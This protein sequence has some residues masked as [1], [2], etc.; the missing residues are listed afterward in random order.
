MPLLRKSVHTIAKSGSTGLTGDV[1]LS[2]GTNVTLTQ[3]GQDISIAAAAAAGATTALDNLASV[4][5]N[6]ALVLATNDGF[7]LGST[8]KQWSDVFL[9]EG[10]VINWDNGDA[11]LT[12]VADVVTL[13]GADLKIS[14]PGT[15]SG[16]VATIDGTQT[17][18]NKS[19]SEAQLTFTDIT[20]G[21]V[22]STKHGFAQKS[23]ADATKFLN[24]GATPAWTV[25]ANTGYALA[26]QTLAYSGTPVD[27][28]IYFWCTGQALLS[29][30]AS[31]TDSRLFV[32]KAGT[33]KAVYGTFDVNGTLG[34][35]ES[36]TYAI[37][38]NN[39][40]DTTISSTAV[41]S[42]AT[43]AFS[44][45]G[46]SIAVVAGDYVELK[47]TCP[48]WVTNPTSVAGSVSIYIE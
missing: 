30:T 19:M 14:T 21:D 41:A 10:G 22:T 39:T 31:G 4:A 48:T 12:Q 44:N 45:S 24:G 46:L 3:S 16:S 43:N 8:T 32:P 18:T 6:A 2:Q 11:T 5:I 28:A 33:I 38:L 35:G 42:S 25:P 27:G 29:N 17:L 37:R 1:T 40:T 20:T 26:V 9:A 15:A 23:P 36:I 47:M 7:A 34:S 13:A